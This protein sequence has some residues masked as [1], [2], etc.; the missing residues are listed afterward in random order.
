MGTPISVGENLLQVLGLLFFCV[1]VE[2]WL[3]RKPDNK[4]SMKASGQDVEAGEWQ[5]KRYRAL[6][7]SPPVVFVFSGP[8]LPS[9]AYVFTGMDSVWGKFAKV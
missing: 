8:Y 1:H 4:E 7:I 5:P 6:L 9:L 3:I 2:K